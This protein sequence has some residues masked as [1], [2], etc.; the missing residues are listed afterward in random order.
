MR[1]L[2]LSVALVAAA[3]ALARE[4][5][6]ESV[7]QV[8]LDL[9]G[10]YWFN[11]GPQFDVHLKVQFNLAHWFALGL[12]PGLLMNLPNP[13]GVQFGLPADGYVRFSVSRLYFDVIGGI[14]VLF[15]DAAP[16]RGH[17]AGGLGVNVI[18]G[19]SIGVEAGW[20]QNGPQ[21]LARFSFVF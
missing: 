4:H 7:V 15:G 18:H 14:A 1:A 3:P 10:G 11:V 5:R 20:L 19:F 16:F 21:L 12:R 13:G 9:G 17:V 6:R 8:G 2:A